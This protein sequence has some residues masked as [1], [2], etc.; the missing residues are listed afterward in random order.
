MTI[1]EMP[2]DKRKQLAAFPLSEMLER[3]A[4][5]NAMADML[6]GRKDWTLILAFYHMSVW[7]E[8][9]GL[10]QAQFQ[11]ALREAYVNA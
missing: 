2:E 6:G 1:R 4:N 3:I 10:T 8:E 5:T 9:N 11:E 7:A